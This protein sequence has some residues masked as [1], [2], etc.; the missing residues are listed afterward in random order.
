MQLGQLGI[1]S[2]RTASDA[3]ND[4]T[5]GG[6]IIFNLAVLHV[7]LLGGGNPA[8][9]HGVLFF[10]TDND[11]LVSCLRIILKGL[12]IRSNQVLVQQE[13]L[14]TDIIIRAAQV[15]IVVCLLQG[16]LEVLPVVVLS[17]EYRKG[18]GFKTHNVFKVILFLSGQRVHKLT[19]TELGN[20]VLVESTFCHA[21]REDMPGIVANHCI[22]TGDMTDD[23][24]FVP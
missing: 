7:C 24:P 8:L 15:Q 19:V 23:N 9:A 16:Y 6:S 11:I 14:V 3:F 22:L 1:L 4:E 2:Q 18:I 5:E 10:L 13:D 12:K 20:S 21:T 17:A